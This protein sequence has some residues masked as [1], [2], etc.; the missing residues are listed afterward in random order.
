LLAPLRDHLRHR[1]VHADGALAMLQQA[2]AAA[3]QPAPSVQ[4]DALAL[5]FANLCV[6][7]VVM[8]RFL[9]HLPAEL[10]AQALAEACRVAA[11]FVVVSFFHPC[12]FH[13]LTRMLRRIGGSPP[14]RFA[15]TLAQVQRELARHGFVLHRSAADLPFARDLWLASFV[16]DGT[17]WPEDRRSGTN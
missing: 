8:F 10:S 15:R 2:R 17:R 3:R 1:V 7:G 16:R 9:H 12:S 4:A 6:D 13:H 11:R 5:P 14:T